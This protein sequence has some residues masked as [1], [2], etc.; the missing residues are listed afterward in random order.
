MNKNTYPGKFFVFEG[1]DGAG[2]S[3]QTNLLASELKK[4]GYEVIKIDFPQHGK[5]SSALVDDYLNGKYGSAKEVGPYVASIFY[6]CDRY[7]A[8]FNIRKWLEQ[9]KIIIADRYLVSN[10]GHQGGKIRDKEERRNYFNWL[11]NLEYNIFKIPKPDYTFILKTSTE[12]SLKLSSEITD[13]EKKA[14]RKA[15]LGDKER[16]IH[17]ED[18]KHQADTLESF[19][20]VVEEYPE[21]FK[22]IECIKN[23][24]LLS[25]EIIHQKIKQAIK[26]KL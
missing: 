18:K 5:R 14:K 1:I 9:G 25:P 10:M 19:L 2:K 3:T 23:K 26:N 7:D 6:A 17:E 12:F 8:S 20:Y 22:V 21:E 24:E 13:A 4:E 16:D 11:H 15:Y